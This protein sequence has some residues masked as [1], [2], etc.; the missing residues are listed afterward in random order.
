MLAASETEIVRTQLRS[1]N[2]N[3]YC[4]RAIQAVQTECL[5]KFIV[6]GEKHLNYLIEQFLPYYHEERP[7][8]GKGN[9]PLTRPATPPDTP[10]SHD[11][12]FCTGRHIPSPISSACVRGYMN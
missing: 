7:H 6:L 11:N 8:Q 9:A 10:L 5:D 1:P 4:D 12:H 2:I 3:A